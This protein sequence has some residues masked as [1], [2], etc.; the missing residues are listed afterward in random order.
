MSRGQVFLGYFVWGDKI[1]GDRKSSYTGVG[2]IRIGYT[3]KARLLID[4]AP[5]A[6]GE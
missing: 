5:K 1:G 6:Q 4:R 3:P 2:V